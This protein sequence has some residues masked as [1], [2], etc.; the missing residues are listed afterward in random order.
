MDGVSVRGAGIGHSYLEDVACHQ[1][2]CN[3]KGRDR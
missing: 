3:G 1:Q 2:I